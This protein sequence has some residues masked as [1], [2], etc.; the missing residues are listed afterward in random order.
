MKNSLLPHPDAAPS[1]D[2]PPTDLIGGLLTLSDVARRLQV[3][4]RTVLRIIAAGKLRPVAVAG[5]K[6]VRRFRPA[7]VAALAQPREDA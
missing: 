4:E 2:I 5:M 7:D 1:L 3:S 6:R